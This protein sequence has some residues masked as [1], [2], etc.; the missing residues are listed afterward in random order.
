MSEILVIVNEDGTIN[1]RT[2]GFQGP[3]CVQ[4]TERLLNHLKEA[5]VEVDAKTQKVEYE[6]TYF[7]QTPVKGGA[8][9]GV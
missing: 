3:S 8:K 4:E 1:L 7:I 6:G 9:V 2:T 5:G